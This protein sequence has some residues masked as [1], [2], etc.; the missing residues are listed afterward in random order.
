MKRNKIKLAI[1]LVCASAFYLA[2]GTTTS[3]SDSSGSITEAAVSAVGGAVNSTVSGGVVG[4]ESLSTKNLEARATATCPIVGS[5]TG[6]ECEASG[7]VI[8]LTFPSGGC[9]YSGSGATW[10]GSTLLTATPSAYVAA[11]S[12][13]PSVTSSSPSAL[14]RTFGGTLASGTTETNGSGTYTVALD[15]S[16]ASNGS[17]AANFVNANG[18]HPTTG[19]GG[20]QYSVPSGQ[21]GYTRTF[22]SAATPSTP[23]MHSLSIG[24][25]LVEYVGATLT[26]KAAFDHT[27]STYSSATTNTPLTV[28]LTSSSRVANDDVHTVNGTLYL[29]H[30]LLKM[31]AQ[32][33]FTNVVH[34]IGSGCCFPTGGTVVTTF[35]G[36]VNNGLKETMAFTTNCGQANFTSV[37]GAKSTITLSHCL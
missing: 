31:T 24:I 28:A 27:L 21:G 37:T 11:C 2:C 1:G 5:F 18:K 13:F 26:G 4:L 33:V 6:S 35:S 34:T 14:T 19:I 30:N 8:T 29:Q 25:R 17:T 15:T 12:G 16:D 10:V 7:N 36:S 3:T 23:L 32:A 20:W 22:V 9:S